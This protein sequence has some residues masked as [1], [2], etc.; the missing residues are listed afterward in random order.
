[1]RPFNL[2]R[3]TL[4][5]GLAGLLALGLLVLVAV[6]FALGSVMGWGT[7]ALD[8][9]TDATTAAVA[10]T[11]ED[12]TRELE[13]AKSDVAAAVAT[14]ATSSEEATRALE[15]ARTA[16]A[17]A[18]DALAEPEAA[19][20][21]VTDAVTLEAERAAAAAVV[22]AAPVLAER[23]DAAGR[24]LDALAGPDP[25]LWPKGLPLRQVHY[26]KGESVTEYGYEATEGFDLA[27]MREQLVAL[28][29][30]E[31]VIAEGGDALEAVYR[32]PQQLV[33]SASLREG[34]QVI[35]VR[36]APLAVPAKPER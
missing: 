25:E 27:Q 17:G 21:R 10:Q 31:H 28:G 13:K 16:V 22:A 4:L 6:V 20:N 1:M 23:A 18:R 11:R 5:V 9:V 33:L 3:R 29:Y 32:G 15:D 8:K 19:L 34:R 2:S 35:D 12:A 14:A 24:V 7:A 26:R 36:E 30:T